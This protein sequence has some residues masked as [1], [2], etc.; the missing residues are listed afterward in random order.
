MIGFI[1]QVFSTIIGLP[2]I[3]KNRDALYEFIRFCLVG[4]LATCIHYFIYFVLQNYLS[5]NV[6]YTVG[7]AISFISNYILSSFFTFKKRVT[8][9]NGIGF[10]V[11]HFLN[12][13]LQLIFLN[14]FVWIG[15]NQKYAPIP[16]FAIAVPLNF[17]M[18]R[19]VFQHNRK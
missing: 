5:I 7:Y 9:Q 6:A 4:V 15:V 16:V 18:V 10:G 17:I 12:Y 19:F 8:L 11:A 2:I 13:I 1:K 14:L 3:K